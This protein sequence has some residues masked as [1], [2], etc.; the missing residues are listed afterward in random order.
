MMW[1]DSCHTLLFNQDIEMSLQNMKT[2]SMDSDRDRTDSDITIT[3]QD[4]IPANLVLNENQMIIEL[5]GVN[6]NLID[7]KNY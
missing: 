2:H 5:V 6:I 1:R 7:T 3:Y 4:H